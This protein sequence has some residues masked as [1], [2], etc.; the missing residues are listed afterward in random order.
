MKTFN[1]NK[2]GIIAASV[3]SAGVVSG[4]EYCQPLLLATVS[5]MI[6][7]AMINRLRTNSPEDTI[8]IVSQTNH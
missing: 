4:C 3:L 8:E 5:T 7:I 1:T 6:I 2:I